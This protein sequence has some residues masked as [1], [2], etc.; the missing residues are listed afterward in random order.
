MIVARLFV[1]VSL[2]KVGFVIAL[3]L[4]LSTDLIRAQNLYVIERDDLFGFS[5]RSGKP[6]IP[7]KY[8]GVK[9]FSEGLAA[10]YENGNWGFIDS[11][12]K[13]KIEADFWDADNFS[14]GLAA[15]RKEGW[16][17]IDRTGRIV[18]QPRY[19][20]ARRFSEEVAPVKAETRWLFIDKAGRPVPDLSGFEDAMSF[21][22]GLAAV[23]VGG[24]WRFINHK[25]KSNLTLSSRK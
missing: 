12:G 5:D 14:E 9:P 11:T 23:Q 15:I 1:I 3:F 2:A 19:L 13:T 20:Q 24:R 8:G 4:V 25:G 17:Y 7:P 22:A 16:G 6:L 21:S 18:V 10:V